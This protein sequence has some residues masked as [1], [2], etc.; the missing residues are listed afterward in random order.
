M[1]RAINRYILYKNLLIVILVSIFSVLILCSSLLPQKWH[2]AIILIMLLFCLSLIIRD[3]KIFFISLFTFFIPINADIQFQKFPNHLGGAQGISLSICDIILFIL[4]AIWIIETGAKNNHK[5]HFYPKISIPMIGILFFY[6]LSL[7]SSVNYSLSLYEIISYIKMYLIFIAIA[8]LV[9]DRKYIRLIITL[10]IFGILIQSII[11]LAQQIS[12]S[13]LGLSV[14]GEEKYSVLS[15]KFGNINF[16]R[17]GGTIGYPNRLAMY[18]VFLLPL[19]ASLFFFDSKKVNKVLY[20][21]VTTIGIITL[22][23]T[24]SRVAWL[25]I[26]IALILLFLIKFKVRGSGFS[27]FLIMLIL[28]FIIINI[29]IKPITIRLFE[30]DYGAARA[31][32]PMI[33][34]ASNIIKQHP[35]FGI[36]I[37]NYSEVI[38]HYDNTPEQIS[39]Y[40]P[41]AVHNLYMF[42]AAET[43]ILSLLLFL[44]ILYEVL[45]C[46]WKNIYSQD[47]YLSSVGI[48]F[49]CGFIALI[50][51]YTVDWIQIAEYTQLWFSIGIIM[52]I[53]NMQKKK[54]HV[55][56]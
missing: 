51:N 38:I 7:A 24:F 6:I 46:C 43:G 37:N 35:I 27:L 56:L 36:G 22:I 41:H 23:F 42:I 26:C 15:A 21:F 9:T 55:R 54:R 8:N 45:R 28:I 49:F 52:A 10:L 4:L 14:L 53:D 5:F 32:I 39:I 13:S 31:R 30:E 34:V 16:I 25:C 48:A 50:I 44:L 11:V 40:D 20:I 33:K 17:T 47:K 18:L 3:K 19:S 12:G 29:F 1:L 2:M